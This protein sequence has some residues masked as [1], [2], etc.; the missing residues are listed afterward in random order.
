MNKYICI[1]FNTGK[2]YKRHKKTQSF[3][4]CPDCSTGYHLMCERCVEFI[5]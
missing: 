2:K 4:E 5:K 1:D 3:C